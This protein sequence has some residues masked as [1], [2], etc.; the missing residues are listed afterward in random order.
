MI[1][2]LIKKLKELNIGVEV[3]HGQLKLSAPKGSIS[4]LLLDEL[5]TNREELILF[6]KKHQSKTKKHLSIPSAPT[7][8]DNGYPISDAQRR[9]WVLS[10]FRGG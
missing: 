2:L 8:R 6:F 7:S 1:N 4:P 9:I 10:Q 3:V 5:K